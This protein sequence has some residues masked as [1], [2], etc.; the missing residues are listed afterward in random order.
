[1]LIVAAILL[2][3]CGV[4]HSVL[5]ERYLLSRLFKRD[6]L[7]HLFGSDAFTKGTLRFAWHIT[8]LCWF[9]FAALLLL[10]PDSTVLLLT[11]GLIFLASGVLSAYYTKG[12]HLSWLVF[13]AISALS[14]GSIV[15]A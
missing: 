14:F 1:M 6:N 7:P 3:L 4:V 9:G 15:V 10:L 13:F 12:K 2:L 11:V 5:G 8:T